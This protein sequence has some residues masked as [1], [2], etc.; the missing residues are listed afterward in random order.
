MCTVRQKPKMVCTPDT[1]HSRECR[2]RGVSRRDWLDHTVIHQSFSLISLIPHTER[3]LLL[4]RFLLLL[5]NPSLQDRSRDHKISHGFERC[6]SFQFSA[7]KYQ[8]SVRNVRQTAIHQARLKRLVFPS[9]S[10]RDCKIFA[11]D[12]WTHSGPLPY[13]YM[14][15]L[16]RAKKQTLNK[17]QHS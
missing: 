8:I 14:S 17:P 15:E 2:L 13:A 9:Y 10:S 1:R 7:M 3:L 12:Y 6:E 4:G 16:L 5:L 11:S